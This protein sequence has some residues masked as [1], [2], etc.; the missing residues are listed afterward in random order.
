MLDIYT[1]YTYIHIF[2][3]KSWNMKNYSPFWFQRWS[4]CPSIEYD[5]WLLIQKKSLFL[6]LFMKFYHELLIKLTHR[7]ALLITRHFSIYLIFLK[8]TYEESSA[9]TQREVNCTIIITVVFVINNRNIYRSCLS[10]SSHIQAILTDILYM[11]C[12]LT[13]LFFGTLSK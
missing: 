4:Y 2:Y 10:I 13:C 12:V 11:E 5:I 9:T 3:I 8:L 6:F 7:R 1:I